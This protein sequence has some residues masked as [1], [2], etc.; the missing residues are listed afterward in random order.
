ME[1]LDGELSDIHDRYER[2]NFVLASYNGGLQ[3][4]RDAMRLA[5]RDGKNP[6]VWD[7]VKPYVLK[8]NL[9]RY[10]RDTLVHAGYMR[11]QETVEYVDHIRQRYMKYRKSAR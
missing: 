9:P 7:Q 11:G 1:E 3:H 10:Y 5:Q 2:E 8:L 6:Q 4:V